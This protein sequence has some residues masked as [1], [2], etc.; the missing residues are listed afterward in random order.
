[1]I[2]VIHLTS[3]KTL[4]E[5]VALFCVYVSV[6]ISLRGFCCSVGCHSM[7][8]FESRRTGPISFHGKLPLEATKPG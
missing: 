4:T 5:C 2:A 6:R 8:A 3:V 1:L 7:C